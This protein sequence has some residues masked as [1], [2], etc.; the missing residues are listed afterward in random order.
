MD[1][2]ELTQLIRNVI[3]AALAKRGLFYVPAAVSA[4]HVHL[5]RGDFEALF[6]KGGAMTRYR[7][8]SQP[9]QFASGQTVEVIGPKGSFKKVRVLGPERGQTQVEISISDSF[10]LGIKPEIRMSGNIAGTPGCTLAGP[11]GRVDIAQGVM[12]AARHIHMSAEQAASYGV[13]DGDEISLKVPGPRAGIIGGV[14]VR[15]GKGH[16]LEVHLDTDEANGNGLLCGTILE[17]VPPGEASLRLSPSA[18]VSSGAAALSDAF[19]STA[20]PSL[21]PPSSALDLV[22]E[23]EINN[24]VQRGEKTVSVT[25]RGFITPAAA[26]RAKVRGI[27]IRRLDSEGR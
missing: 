12:V 7:D 25:A 13:K 22:T 10:S 15:S 4:R 23:R 20:A 5:S 21:Q 11:A 18:G 19:P 3:L 24:A 26:D 8:L 14:T 27:T 1:E 2:R 6:G 9:G 16:D 17:M